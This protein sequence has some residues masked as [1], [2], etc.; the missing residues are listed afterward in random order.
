LLS[1]LTSGYGILYRATIAGLLVKL[2][3]PDSATESCLRGAEAA[4]FDVLLTVDQGIEYEQNLQGRKMAIVVFRAKSNR[5]KDL[6][7]HMES[8]LA[9]LESLQPGEVVRI[10]DS[11]AS[12]SRATSGAVELRIADESCALSGGRRAHP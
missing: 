1:A 9:R 12:S 4:G 10:G 11:S 3:W 5:L 8:C 7:L 2:D 6:L